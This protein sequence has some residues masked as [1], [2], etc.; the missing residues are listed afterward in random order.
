MMNFDTLNLVLFAVAAVL[1]VLYFG[2][3]NRRKAQ[4]RKLMAARR[5]SS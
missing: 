5:R 3:R 2:I 1:G 4:E